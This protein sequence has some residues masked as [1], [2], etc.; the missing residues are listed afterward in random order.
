LP[1]VVS[2]IASTMWICL[3]QA[4]RSAIVRL[5]DARAARPRSLAPGRSAT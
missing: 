4:G 1:T 3:G 5:R 2:G